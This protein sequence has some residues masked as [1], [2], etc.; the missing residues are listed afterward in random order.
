[1]VLTLY[2]QEI[3]FMLHLFIFFSTNKSYRHAIPLLQLSTAY[4]G[5]VL[6]LG[7]HLRLIVKNMLEGEKSRL[8]T[9]TKKREPLTL[10][11]YLNCI[12]QFSKRTMLYHS[13]LSLLV[14]FPLQ[15][16]CVFLLRLYMKRSNIFFES[17]CISIFIST[18]KT[19]IYRV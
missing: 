2:S 5:C 19:D 18:S 12:I 11:C 15:E 16:F 10:L 13:V 4:I 3:S 7:K 17:C 8:A 14:Y 9:H 1:M 6:L